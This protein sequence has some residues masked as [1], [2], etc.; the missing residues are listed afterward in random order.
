MHFF[1]NLSPYVREFLVSKRVQVPPIPAT[2]TNHQGN[3]RLIFFRNAAVEAENKKIAIKF[4]I[5]PASRCLH[6]RKFMGM[7]G[8]NPSIKM[9]GLGNRFQSRYN[10]SMVI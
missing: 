8:G 1:K 4:A 7:H 10:N 5:Q 9:M 6:T 2:Q 3:Q